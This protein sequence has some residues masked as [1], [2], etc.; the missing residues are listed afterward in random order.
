MHD[1]TSAISAA[2]AASA[3]LIKDLRRTLKVRT[4]PLTLGVDQIALS[5][6]VHAQTVRSHVKAGTLPFERISITDGR[7]WRFRTADLLVYLLN[8]TTL[9]PTT[10]TTATP[11]APRKGPGRRVGSQ[12]KKTKAQASGEGA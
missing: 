7:N 5:L 6:G 2:T 11:P 1:A 10:P 12:N 8:D 9:A 3:A 4:L